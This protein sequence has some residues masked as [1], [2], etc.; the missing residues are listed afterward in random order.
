MDP[1]D[2]VVGHAKIERAMLLA[3]KQINV[4]RHR[5]QVV[6]DSG[7]VASVGHGRPKLRPGMTIVWDRLSSNHRTRT[8]HSTEILHG[9]PS[10]KPR[11]SPT[12][13]SPMDS[14][15][16][17]SVGSRRRKAHPGMT[18]R[19]TV[20]DRVTLAMRPVCTRQPHAGRGCKS[21]RLP[22]FQARPVS[23][24]DAGL[25]GLFHAFRA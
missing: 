5:A 23:C 14:G 6:M 1:P 17:P 9:Y 21:Q 13:R 19:M 12:A 3:R 4:I 7:L 18:A 8:A 20:R 10:T 15:P 16:E 25:I 2:N 11:H 22:L 24:A